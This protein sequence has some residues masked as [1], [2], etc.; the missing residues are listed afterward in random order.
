MDLFA[1]PLTLGGHSALFRQVAENHG[2]PRAPAAACRYAGTV[3]QLT[4]GFA[5]FPQGWAGALFQLLLM[6]GGLGEAQKRAAVLRNNRLAAVLWL[7]FQEPSRLYQLVR[8][9]AQNVLP[10]D[11]A[12]LA[13]RFG[14]GYFTAFALK[15][16]R[17]PPQL[18]LSGAVSNFALAS[19]GS[20]ILAVAKGD[21]ALHA[22]A[23]AILSG[24]Y[25]G[26]CIPVDRL[27]R[28]MRQL[29]DKEGPDTAPMVE[30]LR[31]V[32]RLAEAAGQD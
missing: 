15:F 2:D 10:K 16:T 24:R 1:P 14:G 29:D 6:S 25:D 28:E 22:I 20:A 12:F 8:W 31:D 7:A 3:D 5:S 13:A 17:L 26:L 27:E 30:L 4:Q 19:Y 32:L 23:V 21:E 18:A 11:A 9:L